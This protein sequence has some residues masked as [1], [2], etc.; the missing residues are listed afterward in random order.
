MD[1]FNLMTLC[2][3]NKCSGKTNVTKPK[4]KDITLLDKYKPSSNS[5]VPNEKSQC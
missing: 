2:S 3:G 1:F 5:T 4:Q